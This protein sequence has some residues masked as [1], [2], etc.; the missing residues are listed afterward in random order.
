MLVNI[1]VHNLSNIQINSLKA[2]RGD[3][4]ARGTERG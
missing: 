1:F 4:E 3:T 2:R